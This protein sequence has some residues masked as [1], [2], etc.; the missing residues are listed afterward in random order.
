MSATYPELALAEQERLGR[1]AAIA[2]ATWPLGAVSLREFLGTAGV[3]QLPLHLQD[4]FTYRPWPTHS[5]DER[6]IDLDYVPWTPPGAP[7]TIGHVEVVGS[8]TIM[9]DGQA[10]MVKG[11]KLRL[12]N[13]YLLTRD[14][15]LRYEE[16]RQLASDPVDQEGYVTAK[17]ENYARLHALVAPYKLLVDMPGHTQ[18]SGLNPNLR[19]SYY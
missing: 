4:K 9:I 2:Q 8:H 18:M 12:L 1:A 16:L 7:E 6:I 5:L 3:R 10:R 15:A 13:V 11:N 17:G 14:W 19:F